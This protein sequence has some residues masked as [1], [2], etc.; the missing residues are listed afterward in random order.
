[1]PNRSVPKKSTEPASRSLPLVFL[2]PSRD[3]HRFLAPAPPAPVGKPLHWPASLSL[4]R[5]S[6]LPA[7]AWIYVAPIEDNLPCSPD[8][9]SRPLLPA[10]TDFS[11]PPWTL[12]PGHPSSSPPLNQICFPVATRGEEAISMPY[13]RRVVLDANCSKLRFDICD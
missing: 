10:K 4:L 11:S 2:P 1:M 5:C 9:C 13:H 12:L 3:S 8:L 6:L 7:L